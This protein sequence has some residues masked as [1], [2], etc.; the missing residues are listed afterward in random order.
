MKRTAFIFPILVLFFAVFAAPANADFRVVRVSANDVLNIRAAPDPG[1]AKLGTIPAKGTGITATG[2][3]APYGNFIWAEITYGGVTGWVNKHYLAK[4]E[5]RAQTPPPAA[6][7]PTQHATPEVTGSINRQAG[8]EALSCSGTEPFWGM[9]LKGKETVFDSLGGGGPMTLKLSP[10]TQSPQMRTVWA[11]D[12]KEK[13]TGKTVSI[14]VK[15]T[16]QCSDGMSDIVFP[17]ET[18]V[19]VAGGPVYAGCC[20][21][22]NEQ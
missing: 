3:T 7:A 20:N 12:A 11:I 14:T 10:P 17:Y 5:R 13:E 6:P 22:A 1:A 21:I 19:N 4:E 2:R 18:L 15:K 9:L 16:G 8:L